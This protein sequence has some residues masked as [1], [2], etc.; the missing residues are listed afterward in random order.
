MKPKPLLRIW[1][2][3]DK[4]GDMNRLRGFTSKR[5]AQRFITLTEMQWPGM[6]KYIHGPY[7]YD[8]REKKP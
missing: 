1:I 6:G 7:A 2:L 5:A 8:L 4:R 3:R